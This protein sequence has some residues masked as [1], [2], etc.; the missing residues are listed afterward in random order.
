MLSVHIQF[1]QMKKPDRG[2]LVRLFPVQHKLV[3]I[4][5]DTPCG[6]TEPEAL[7]AQCFTGLLFA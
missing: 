7:Q 6:Y 4:R 1:N 5:L 2:E 3:V